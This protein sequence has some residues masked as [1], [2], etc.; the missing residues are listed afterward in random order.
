VENDFVLTLSRSLKLDLPYPWRPQ[1]IAATV[2]ATLVLFAQG[3]AEPELLLTRRSDDLEH[4]RGQ[5][6]FPGGMKEEM[7]KNEEMTALREA[8]EEVG[9]IPT[10]VQVLGRLPSLLTL[11]GYS[12]TPVV[13]VLNIPRREFQMKLNSAEVAEAFWVPLSILLEPKIYHY[14]EMERGGQTFPIDVFTL[15]GHRVWGA[16]GSMVKNLVDRIQTLR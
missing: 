6:A 2:S 12:I 16:T 14:E 15:N 4:H 10:Q 1:P 5:I 7:D 8:H 13:G 9:I 3:E 11:T